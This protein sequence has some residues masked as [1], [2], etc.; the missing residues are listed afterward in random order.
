[1]PVPIK[2]IQNKLDNSDKSCYMDYSFLANHTPKNNKKKIVQASNRDAQLVFDIWT[3][4]K[5]SNK[6]T[7]KIDPEIAT[8]RDIM[9]LKA[10]GFVKGSSDE[11]TLT[12]RGKTII[13]TIV[14]AEPSRFDKNSQ[15][16]PYT[17]IL[18]SMSKKGKDGYRI[19]RYSSCTSNNIDLRKS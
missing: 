2:P 18:A 5:K 12:D 15:N 10:L 9:R 1:M 13:S 3:Q 14:M 4:A 16:K 11:V 6:D 17:E 19:P 7:F 8:M